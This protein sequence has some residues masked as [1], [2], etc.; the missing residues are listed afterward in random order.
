MVQCAGVCAVGESAASLQHTEVTEPFRSG[1]TQHRPIRSG[2]HLGPGHHTVHRRRGNQ[3][4]K[5]TRTKKQIAHRNVLFHITLYCT[6]PYCTTI[7]HCTVLLYYSILLYHTVLLYY[8]TT[9]LYHTVLLYY[10]TLYC[11][12]ILCYTT[13][14]SWIYTE[15]LYLHWLCGWM[16]SVWIYTEC[17]ELH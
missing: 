1:D 14:L 10:T 7:L 16:L 12:T 15:C 17:A 11:T 5:H 13:I 8:T 3:L 6:T 2:H 4:N 9:L